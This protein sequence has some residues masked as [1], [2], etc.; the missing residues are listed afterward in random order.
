[1]DAGAITAILTQ[2][3]AFLGSGSS[4]NYNPNKLA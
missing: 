3:L 1:M 2:V 4:I